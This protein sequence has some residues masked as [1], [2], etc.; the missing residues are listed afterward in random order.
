MATIPSPAPDH[1]DAKEAPSAK[2]IPASSLSETDLILNLANPEAKADAPAKHIDPRWQEQY[3]GL[4]TFRDYLL[5]QISGHENEA[6]EVQPDPIQDPGAESATSDLL[7]DYLLGMTST[8]QDTL[9]EVDQALR[10]IEDGT[11]GTCEFTG[12]PIPAE[13]LKAVPWTRYTV[14]AQALMER[15]NK[16]PEHASVGTLP[17][18]PAPADLPAPASEAGHEVGGPAPE[19]TEKAHLGRE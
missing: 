18:Q 7:R 6:R 11:Y 4:R 8:E 16:A 15:H 9:G 19:G 14:E 12:K 17:Y 10:R 1:P 5:D 13:R 2:S 3:Q